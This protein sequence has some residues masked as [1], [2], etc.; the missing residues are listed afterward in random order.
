MG[1][2][3]WRSAASARRLDTV[4]TVGSV[5]ASMSKDFVRQRHL[6]VAICGPVSRGSGRC[7]PAAFGRVLHHFVGRRFPGDVA[8]CLLSSVGNRRKRWASLAAD[9]ASSTNIIGCLPWC[10]G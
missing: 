6:L 5:C 1:A 4:L 2:L 10:S 7:W 3:A 9:D 8:Y